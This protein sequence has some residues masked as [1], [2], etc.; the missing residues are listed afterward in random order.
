MDIRNAKNPTTSD[1]NELSISRIEELE[2]RQHFSATTADIGINVNDASSSAMA[3][4]IPVM[5]QMGITTVRLY[6]GVDYTNHDFGGVLK[7]AVD[8]HNAGFDVM[9]VVQ[10]DSNA[11]PSAS[12][13]KGWFQWAMG[14]TALKNAVDRWEVGNEVDQDSYFKGTLQQYMTKRARAGVF[15]PAR[16]WRESRLGRRELEPRRHP[17]H[18]RRRPAQ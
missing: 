6:A 2:T 16:R 3:K 7:R 17:D 5:K 8:Y 15:R 10:S 12:Q 1:R 13:V 14:N 9:V 11:V 18:D 4:A